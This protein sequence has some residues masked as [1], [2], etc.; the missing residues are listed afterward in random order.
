MK[1]KKKVFVG[2]TTKEIRPCWTIYNTFNLTAVIQKTKIEAMARYGDNSFDDLS[3]VRIT[4]EE[5]Q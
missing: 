3:K 1:P 2:Y 5:I 4:I